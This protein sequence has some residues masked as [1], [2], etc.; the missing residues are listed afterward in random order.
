MSF[1][2]L[3]NADGRHC[4]TCLRSRCDGQC[5]FGLLHR[6]APSQPATVPQ[7]PQRIV[8]APGVIEGPHRRSWVVRLI[9]IFQSPGQSLGQRMGQRTDLS[10]ADHRD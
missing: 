1:D 5:T 7:S 4:D 8:F 3:F 10:G 9:G 6:Q 2:N